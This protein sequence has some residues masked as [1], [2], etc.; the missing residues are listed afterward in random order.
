MV[1]PVEHA[2]Q[3]AVDQAAQLEGHVPPV[4][5]QLGPGGAKGD[6]TASTPGSSR[7]ST[8]WGR[9]G[10]GIRGPRATGRGLAERGVDG[11][12]LAGE[13]VTTEAG[14]GQRRGQGRPAG[15]GHRRSGPV[16]AR[17]PPPRCRAG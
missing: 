11:R 16:P 8:T 13:E 2:A 17:R 7:A 10:A 3:V 6:A 9:V 12:P 14:D 1:G 15:G 4:L 5:H